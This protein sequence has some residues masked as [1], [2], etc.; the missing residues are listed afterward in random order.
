MILQL[1]KNATEATVN[2][3]GPDEATRR[4]I[5][6]TVVHGSR[7]LLMRIS[8]QGKQPLVAP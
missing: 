2:S 5:T 3:H 1:L 6:V 4:P 7:D 8:D